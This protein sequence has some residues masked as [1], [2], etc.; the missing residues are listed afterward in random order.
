[1]LWAAQLNR[2]SLGLLAMWY[3]S[4]SVWPPLHFQ[5][6]ILGM[7]KEGGPTLMSPL[8]CITCLLCLVQERKTLQD[9]GACYF[10]FLN[11]CSLFLTLSRNVFLK[12]LLL[13]LVWVCA[14]HDPCVVVKG[15]LGVHSLLPPK[16]SVYET[17]FIRLKG[18]HLYLPNHLVGPGL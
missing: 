9:G 8:P 10:P 13:Y 12:L 5:G 2:V 4:G 16:N 14:F 15:T 7:G 18:K 6:V 11:K 1:M 3:F 17:Q